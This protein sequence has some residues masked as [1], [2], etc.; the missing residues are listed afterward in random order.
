MH[1]KHG[2]KRDLKNVSLSRSRAPITRIK[3]G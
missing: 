3:P 2:D 1:T